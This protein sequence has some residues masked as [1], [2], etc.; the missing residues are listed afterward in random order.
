MSFEE[1]QNLLAC[2]GLRNL[3]DLLDSFFRLILISH[4]NERD[5]I[6]EI[7]IVLGVGNNIP[8]INNLFQDTRNHSFF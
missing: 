3:I 1:A 4:E 5:K 6:K 8:L 2:K 7:F